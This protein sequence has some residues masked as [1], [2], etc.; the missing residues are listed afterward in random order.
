MTAQ[1][2]VT[3][4]TILNSCAIV[5]LIY[6]A[7]QQRKRNVASCAKP[8]VPAKIPSAYRPR[9]S[10]T[11]RCNTC[12]EYSSAKLSPTKVYS[13]NPRTV[14][15]SATAEDFCSGATIKNNS[16]SDETIVNS[17]P[18]ASMNRIE[19]MPCSRRIKRPR[20]LETRVSAIPSAM[21]SYMA[22]SRRRSKK[23]IIVPDT[24]TPLSDNETT[25]NV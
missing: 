5:G 2:F 11:T 23:K 10:R 17:T 16:R 6:H 1:S 7:I 14:V 20:L 3:F 15:R 24:Y 8:T 18:I 21:G 4:L 25:D 19:E 22:R 12:G 13:R 9:Q